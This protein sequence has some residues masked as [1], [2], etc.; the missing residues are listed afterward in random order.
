[1]FNRAAAEKNELCELLVNCKRLGRRIKENRFKPLSSLSIGKQIPPRELADK[2]VENYIRTFEGVL[3]IV[4]IPTF[5][6]EY[7]RY[8]QNP[9]AA[10]DSFVI[11]LQLCMALGCVVHDD[12]Y[13]MRP[14]ASQWVHEAQ[15][16]LIIPPEKGRMTI[17]GI[18]IRCLLCLARATASVSHDLIWSFAGSLVRI[19]MAM[20][21]HRDPKHLTQ[22]TTY[23]AEMRRRLWAT[24]L[25]LNLQSS[26]DAGGS[27][28]LSNLDYDTALP[29][30]MDDAELTD[31]PDSRSEKFQR[32]DRPTG[33]SVQLE[34]LKSLQLRMNLL[35]HTNE[36]KNSSS[37]NE[38][39]RLNSE[40]TRACRTLSRTLVTFMQ[41]Q[42]T[43]GGHQVTAF[44]TSMAEILVY[45]G[46]HA[47]HQPI[48]TRSFTDP[49]FYFSR[50]MCVESSLKIMDISALS[51]PRGSDITSS[52]PEHDI[53][54]RRLTINASGLFRHIRMQALIAAVLELIYQKGEESHNLG[55]LSA[56]ENSDLRASMDA[57]A[58]WLFARIRSGETNTKGNC[59]LTSCL[60]HADA[61]EMGL[62]PEEAEDMVLQ[63][64][65]E[66]ARTCWQILKDVAEREGVPVHEGE[67]EAM[68]LD[69]EVEMP[70]EWLRSWS[71]DEF[72]QDGPWSGF[73]QSPIGE[74]YQNM[75]ATL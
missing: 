73:P 61:L 72:P 37:Y 34:L 66:T 33:M 55:Y 50:K 68:N 15:L 19:A 62:G 10:S 42:P 32:R 69:L 26:F 44:H 25:E 41:N 52:A 9:D 38:T 8:W 45:R 63:K 2:L 20:G 22:M 70:M 6:A 14:M 12:T 46:F 13:S 27:S 36:F 7:E 30:N 4:H 16:W 49:K 65:T 56:R 75:T 21:L 11:Q 59:F 40:L 74:G 64:T 39:L 51:R 48:I 54:T 43:R 3:R 47:L 71:W 5:R 31:E 17:A 23:R 1:M 18:Q 29:A 24:I 28:L 53:D 58:E 67:E 60:S 57:A 35:K